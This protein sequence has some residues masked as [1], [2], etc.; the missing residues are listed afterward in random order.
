[1]GDVLAI[2]IIIGSFA[3]C[4]ALVRGTARII[5]DASGRSGDE[6]E[7]TAGPEPPIDS[8]ADGR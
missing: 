5:G 1:V 6:V 8:Q 4:I 7:P 3:G 2:V